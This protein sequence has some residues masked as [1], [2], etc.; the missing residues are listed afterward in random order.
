[1]NLFY[2]ILLLTDWFALKQVK[3]QYC[4]TMTLTDNSKFYFTADALGSAAIRGFVQ[5]C[6]RSAGSQKARPPPSPQNHSSLKD[7]GLLPSHS[8]CVATGFVT[9]LYAINTAARRAVWLS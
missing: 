7:G 4:C 8:G 2:F 1:M 5:Q 6:P 3:F 9:M